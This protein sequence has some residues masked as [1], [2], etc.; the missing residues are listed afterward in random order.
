MIKINNYTKIMFDV[1][2]HINMKYS[3]LCSKGGKRAIP[4]SVEGD[5]CDPQSRCAFCTRLKSPSRTSLTYYVLYFVTLLSFLLQR[6]WLLLISNTT[7]MTP[8]FIFGFGY[9]LLCWKMLL[10]MYL[11]RVR[12]I[13]FHKLFLPLSVFRHIANYNIIVL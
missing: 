3:I 1:K 7:A 8:Q 13:L 10:N 12:Q 11:N 5:V 4:I 6:Q 2:K 9:L